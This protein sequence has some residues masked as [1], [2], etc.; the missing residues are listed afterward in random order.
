MDTFY[1]EVRGHVLHAGRMGCQTPSLA[2]IS[3][4]SEREVNSSTWEPMLW[5][6]KIRMELEI[7]YLELWNRCT[8]CSSENRVVDEYNDILKEIERRME[9]LMVEVAQRMCVQG[10]AYYD[11]QA[12]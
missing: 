7:L 9:E 10:C 3:H 12:I 6:S 8:K 1:L 5:F 2:V 4:S 11:M